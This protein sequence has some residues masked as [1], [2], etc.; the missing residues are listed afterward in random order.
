MLN[1]KKKIVENPKNFRFRE[2]QFNSLSDFY[3][4]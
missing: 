4:N 2:V 3:E 1:I